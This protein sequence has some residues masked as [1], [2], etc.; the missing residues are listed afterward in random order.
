[1]RRAFLTGIV[2]SIG[3]FAAR[4]EAGGGVICLV[5]DMKV[6]SSGA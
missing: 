6:A 4:V 5:Q 3:T 2:S 1:M